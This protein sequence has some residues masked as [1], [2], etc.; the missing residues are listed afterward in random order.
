MPNLGWLTELEP[1]T[2]IIIVAVAGLSFAFSFGF[3][4]RSFNARVDRQISK[5][6]EETKEGTRLYNQVD[7]LAYGNAIAIKA[8]TGIDTI[9]QSADGSG[10]HALNR[11]N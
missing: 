4:V 11:D 10:D 7:K 1:M 9:K 8:A 3:Y 2:A 5:L 6:F